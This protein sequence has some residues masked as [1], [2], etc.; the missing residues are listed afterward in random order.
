MLL[1]TLSI[2]SLGFV[3]ASVVP[4]ARFAQP[5]GAAMMYLMLGAV[6]RVH[7]R[8]SVCRGGCR[9]SRTRCRRRTPVTL[10]RAIWAGEGWGSQLATV[11]ALGAIFARVHRV[12][13]ALVSVGVAGSGFGGSGVRGSD[14]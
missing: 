10:M 4:T 14:T 2:L 3:I 1:G 11:G 13:G 7:R 9:W 6:G 8:W 12:L 5:L